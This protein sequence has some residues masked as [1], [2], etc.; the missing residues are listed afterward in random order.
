MHFFSIPPEE[1]FL[2]SIIQIQMK[3]LRTVPW[4][5]FI[6]RVTVFCEVPANTFGQR[7]KFFDFRL[8]KKHL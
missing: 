7:R 2:L 3:F 4:E 8:E 5:A 6:L 1:C